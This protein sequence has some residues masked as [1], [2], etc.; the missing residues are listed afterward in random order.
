MHVCLVTAPT[1]TE[2][3]SA[4]ELS[5]DAIRSSASDPQ[6]G[7]L[8]IAAILEARG[9]T[10]D[11]VDI[12]DAYMHFAKRSGEADSTSFADIVASAIVENTADIYG[13]GSICSTYPLTV[14]IARAVKS[15]RPQAIILFGGPQA[16]VV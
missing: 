13:F 10:P 3:R 6:L 2:L 11:I 15:M 5:V 8:S 1:V 7:I 9:D 14:R 4:Q 12:N 16:S